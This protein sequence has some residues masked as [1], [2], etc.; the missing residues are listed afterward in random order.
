MPESYQGV[1]TAHSDRPLRVGRFSDI[2]ER[3]IVL[4]PNLPQNLVR[5]RVYNICRIASLCR[6]V[7]GDFLFAGIS[8]GVVSR[9]VYEYVEFSQLNKTM[10]LI[11][12]FMGINDASGSST[13][14]TYNTDP[15]YVRM[16][17]RKDAPVKFYLATIPNGLPTGKYAFAHF[18][19]GDLQSEAAT[20]PALFSALSPG[21]AMI[22]DA[23]GHGGGSFDVYDPVFQR[24]GAETLW[25]PSGQVVVF[26]L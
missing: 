11:D 2:Y 17:Y 16:Q 21:G 12:P 9:T 25:L 18:G 13:R 23:Y 8:Y 24:L 3:F 7:D 1:S 20:I 19:T 15:D 10:H 6:H 22:V 5:Y 14:P 26:K 4:D